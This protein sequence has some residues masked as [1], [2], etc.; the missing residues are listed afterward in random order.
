MIITC[1]QET[2]VREE[3]KNATE[4][5]QNA[6]NEVYISILNNIFK[7]CVSQQA[8]TYKEQSLAHQRLQD[9]NKKKFDQ[10]ISEMCATL[11]K[12]K[13]NLYFAQNLRWK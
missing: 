3:M 1:S 6:L 11:E 10:E 8:K 13:V 7:M 2:Q 9:D 5:L 4:L 12:Y